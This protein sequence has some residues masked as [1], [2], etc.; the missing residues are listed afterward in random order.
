MLAALVAIINVGVRSAW[1]LKVTLPREQ[2]IQQNESSVLREE[3]Q[4]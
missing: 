4:V 2:F 3:H 1:M